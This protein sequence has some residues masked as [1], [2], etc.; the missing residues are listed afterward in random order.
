M[1]TLDGASSSTPFP[2]PGPTGAVI[3]FENVTKVYAR[4]ARPALDRVSLDVERGEFVFLVGASGSGKSTF[5]RLVLREELLQPLRDDLGVVLAGAWQQ[6]LA[7]ELRLHVASTQGGGDVLLD[8]LA[9]M[10]ASVE[11]AGDQ[12]DAHLAGGGD[13]EDDVR[14]LT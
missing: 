4:G 3:R 13:V 14:E 11:A 7:V 1:P 8:E 12:V 9:E 6:V 5:L 10:N 2:D